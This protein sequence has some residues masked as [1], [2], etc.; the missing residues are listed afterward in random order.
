LF[1]LKPVIVFSVAAFL[2]SGNV[3]AQESLSVSESAQIDPI[4]EIIVEGTAGWEGH[5]G[6][7]AFLNGDF[8]T[9]EIIF[10]KE[11]ISLKRAKNGRY[12]TATDAA[13]SQSRASNL[14]Q[15]TSNATSTASSS[16][17]NSGT[18]ANR[19]SGNSNVSGRSSSR[20]KRGK[21]LLNDGVLSDQ[22]FALTKYMSGLSELKLGKYDEA[23]KS[24]KSS[25]HYDR[26]N[27][28]ARMRLGLLYLKE[29]NY[30]K[31][32]DHLEELERRRVKCKKKNCHE[33]EELLTA[34][35]ILARE[36]TNKIHQ[37]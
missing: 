18:S 11:F 16:Q 21:N 36:I 5:A 37:K 31:A 28:D 2:A 3:M 27:P 10:E 29:D 23:K 19:T 13:L 34:A 20:R 14:G 15:A 35:S 4:D 9:A 6:M 32:A 1:T 24:L 22:D 12:N 26:G 17:G 30:D 8:E 7:N 33:Y 25:L